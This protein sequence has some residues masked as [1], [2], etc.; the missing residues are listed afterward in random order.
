MVYSICVK[1]FLPEFSF[2]FSYTRTNIRHVVLA[3]AVLVPLQDSPNTLLFYMHYLMF[4][5]LHIFFI[6]T[7]LLILFYHHIS[8]SLSVFC[9]LDFHI[10]FYEDSNLCTALLTISPFLM[11]I[12]RRSWH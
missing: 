8:F 6:Y 9:F 1:S 4:N 5:F 7:V 3:P 10:F 11:N 12:S 2:Y